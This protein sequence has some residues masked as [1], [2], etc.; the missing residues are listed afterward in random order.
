MSIGFQRVP[1]S[2]WDDDGIATNNVNFPD[3]SALL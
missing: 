2:L 1:R 3:G